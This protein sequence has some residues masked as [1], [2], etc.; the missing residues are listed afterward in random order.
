MEVL[1]CRASC[2]RG[3]R[4]RWVGVCA[5]VEQ[6]MTPRVRCLRDNAPMY[7]AAVPKRAGHFLLEHL[8]HPA[9]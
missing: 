4:G 6:E 5:Q 2:P 3:G 1:A 7:L 8:R 9:P